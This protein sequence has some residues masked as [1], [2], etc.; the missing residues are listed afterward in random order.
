[1]Q[2]IRINVDISDAHSDGMRSIM[3]Y[4]PEQTLKRD[5]GNYRWLTTNNS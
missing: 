1:M 5:L 2:D 3:L 4:L